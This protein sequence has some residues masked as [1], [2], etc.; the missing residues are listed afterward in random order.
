MDTFETTNSLSK[1]TACL[2]VRSTG[3]IIAEVSDVMFLRNSF[4]SPKDES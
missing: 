3:N 1:R 2:P 4:H